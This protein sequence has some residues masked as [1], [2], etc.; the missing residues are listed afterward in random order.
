MTRSTRDVRFTPESRHSA[1]LLRRPLCVPQ[2]DV[3]QLYRRRLARDV[4]PL[5]AVTLDTGHSMVLIPLGSVLHELSQGHFT[6][7]GKPGEDI[8]LIIDPDFF[9]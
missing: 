3:R 6:C 5:R 2:A 9:R 1:A 4:I 7:S 8:A